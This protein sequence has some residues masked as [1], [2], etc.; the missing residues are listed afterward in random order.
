VISQ[1]EWNLLFK[2]LK[3]LCKTAENKMRESVVGFLGDIYLGIQSKSNQGAEMFAD[4][5]AEIADFMLTLGSEFS[6][7]MDL[8]FVVGD[9]L[10]V[11]VGGWKADCMADHL[12]ILECRNE[13]RNYAAE[14]DTI[15]K[16][17]L[18]WCFEQS[19]PDKN[20][21]NRKAACVWLLSVL[22]NCKE[23]PTVKDYL[24]DIHSSFSLLLS[25]R[26]DF[27]Q[28]VASKGIGMVYELGDEKLKKEMVESL[29]LLLQE[30]RKIAPQSISADTQLF[31]QSQLGE[32]PEGSNITTYQSIMSL[33]AEMNQ[34]DL[35]YKFM[36]M[37]SHNAIWTSRRGAS[38][39]VA[40]ILSLSEKD[41]EPYMTKMVPKLYRF[42]FD[43][44]PKVSEAM[45]QIWHAL[46]KDE[47]AV[48][49]KYFKEIMDELLSGL[50]DRTWRTR[51]AS[52]KAVSDLIHGKETDLIEPYVEQL[53][54]MAFRALDDIKESVR[55]AALNTC[56]TLAKI[57]LKYT[58]PEF[59]RASEGQK[60]IDIVLPFLLVYLTF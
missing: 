43:P 36:N 44:T 18:K 48:Q 34:P 33:A 28:E 54:N 32:T 30:G 19:L 23:V 6:K 9:S 29:V 47:K 7:H 21:V 49:V 2:N 20:L 14:P 8:L 24:K 50:G 12:D 40:N 41:M 26:D 15:P 22:S 13:F 45:K 37:A 46:V 60:I 35:V 17:I 27:I 57:S 56:Q 25:D 11:L 52:C 55:V 16:K 5:M 42:L 38:L 59:T 58:D 3:S 53:W 10:S 51:E 1:D 4:I 39:G 31:S